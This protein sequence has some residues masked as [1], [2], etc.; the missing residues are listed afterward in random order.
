MRY[1]SAAKQPVAM[2][3]LLPGERERLTWPLD[4]RHV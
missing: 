1:R 3:E 2:G 4:Q